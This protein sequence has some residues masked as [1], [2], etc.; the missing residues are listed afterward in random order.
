MNGVTD[1]DSQPG[2]PVLFLDRAIDGNTLA[3][4]LIAAGAN[5]RRHR[6]VFKDN[7]NDC[8]W[9]SEVGKRKW[10]V[11]TK[12]ARI[13]YNPLEIQA[14]KSAHVGAFIFVPKNL[15]GTEI[16]TVIKRALPAI[17]ATALTKPKPFIVKIYRDGTLKPTKL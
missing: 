8:I 17:E 7:E 10:F 2:R 16:A 1:L 15:T 9:L 5:I 11:I 6:D 3:A 14:L 12:D 4:T 13:R